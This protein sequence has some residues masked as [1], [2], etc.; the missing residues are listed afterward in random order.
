M[1]VL[2]RLAVDEFEDDEGRRD[3]GPGSPGSSPASIT[4]TTCGWLSWA[5]E[6]ASRRKRSSWS[7]SEAISRCI[8]LIATGVR[9]PCRKPGRRST[10]RR[11]RPPLEAVAPGDQRSERRH[12][13]C[14]GAAAGPEPASAAGGRSRTGS[15][16]RSGG[17][18]QQARA[19]RS[20]DRK[21][22]PAGGCRRRARG[23]GRGRR[24]A[25]PSGRRA[26]DHRQ[27]DAPGERL[28]GVAARSPRARA[29]VSVA[30]FRETPGISAERLGQPHREAVGRAELARSL[31]RPA[32]V[33]RVGVGHRE[34]RRAM[35]P[36]AIERGPPSRPRSAVEQRTR[37]HRGKHRERERE[38]WP[39]SPRARAPTSSWRM[40]I[41]SAR[42]APSVQR[43]LEGLALVLVQPRLRPAGQ[44]GHQRVCARTRP[45]AALSAPGAGPARSRGEAEAPP[46]SGLGI[47]RRLAARVR[48]RRTRA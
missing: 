5:T 7:E 9:A 45:G 17:A 47:G 8:S 20:V 27:R 34:R 23:R 35:R 24:D 18:A 30:P 22:R 21:A 13:P 19:H 1:T 36:A 44:P 43:D 41:A 12:A 26:E 31:A 28:R 37:E 16:A 29:A 33:A 38:P 42:P 25:C 15:S 10:C 4:A 3:V 6:R 32:P 14:A 2:Q 46:R 39:G 48:R 40:S 11:G